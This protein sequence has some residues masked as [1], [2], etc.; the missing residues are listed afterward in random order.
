MA[1][2]I[3]RRAIALGVG[4]PR[5]DEAV[6]QL[7]SSLRNVG[8][9]AAALAVLEAEPVSEGMRP[10]AAAFRVLALRDAGRGDEAVEVALLALAPTL[11]RYRDA[12]ARYARREE[13]G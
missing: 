13:R 11:P 9:P 10:A 12:V 1:I 7:A 4:G 6:I 3:Y 5:R 8:D 2:G